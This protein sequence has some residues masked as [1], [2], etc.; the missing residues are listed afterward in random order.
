[1]NNPKKSYKKSF[2]KV[3]AFLSLISHMYAQKLKSQANSVY[4]IGLVLQDKNGIQFSWPGSGIEY[5]AGNEQAN[6]TIFQ[7]NNRISFNNFLGIEVNGKWVAKYEIKDGK[8]K[9]NPHQITTIKEGDSVRII[10]LTESS[11][12]TI[13]LIL[14]R[15]WEMVNKRL[16]NTKKTIHFIGDS[17]TCGYGNEVEVEAPPKG[18]PQTGFHPENENNYFAWGSI[19]ARM[20]NM[21]YVCTAYS[22]KG[23]IRNFDGSENQTM[24]E[25]WKYLLPESG[26][27]TYK[28]YADYFVIHLGTNDFFNG[29]LDSSKFVSS[30]V[31]LAEECLG[32]N[33]KASVILCVSNGLTDLWPKG[34]MR[35][36]FHQRYVVSAQEYLIRQ[37]NKNSVFVLDLPTQEPP[38]RRRLASKQKNTPA[39]GSHVSKSD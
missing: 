31:S 2:L 25:L 33:S 39:N 15:N 29:V 8:N 34:E 37:K 32:Y 28:P 21:N 23:L 27:N 10:K 12:G 1:M 6:F 13:H 24:M 17:F 9:L 3:I 19:A 36:S 5:I 16:N 18:N 20:L 38:I 26:L 22:G 30:L 14:E 7:D 4:P 35:R 11:V